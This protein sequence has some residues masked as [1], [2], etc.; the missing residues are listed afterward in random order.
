MKMLTGYVVMGKNRND[1]VPDGM[2]ML[3]DFVQ[4][5]GGTVVKVVD[6]PF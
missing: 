1:D 5:I 6:R 2:A 4:T 3:A